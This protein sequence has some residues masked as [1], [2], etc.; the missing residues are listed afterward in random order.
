MK[1]TEREELEIAVSVAWDFDAEQFY[2]TDASGL[3]WLRPCENHTDVCDGYEFFYSDVWDNSIKR[4]D[5]QD[6]MNMVSDN[7]TKEDW[8]NGCACM[9]YDWSNASLPKAE[10][11]RQKKLDRHPQAQQDYLE[12]LERAFAEG[13]ERK[14]RGL[15]VVPG[16]DEEGGQHR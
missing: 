10:Y 9:N 1:L 15:P 14:K 16:E 13:L 2:L 3:G 7:W 6:L 5:D 4:L 8:F 11:D 12:A